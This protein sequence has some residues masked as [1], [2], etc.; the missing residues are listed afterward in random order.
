MMMYSSY[1]N[2]PLYSA[3]QTITMEQTA[4]TGTD[5]IFYP[6]AKYEAWEG[7][8]KNRK[9]RRTEAAKRRDRRIKQRKKHRE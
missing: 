3:T 6:T 5:S 9:Q 4:I 1:N 2:G 7:G 8:M